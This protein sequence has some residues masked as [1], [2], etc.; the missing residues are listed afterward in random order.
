MRALHLFP[1][2]LGFLVLVLL[3]V[4]DSAGTAPALGVISEELDTP[5]YD[6]L[7]TLQPT[8]DADT[9]QVW[10]E[11]DGQGQGLRLRLT[12]QALVVDSISGTQETRIAKL[13]IAC[14]PDHP[15]RCFVLR[16]GG[17]LALALAPGEA[18]VWRGEVARGVGAR[19]VIIPGAGWRVDEARIQPLEPVVFADNFMRTKDES[20]G[21]RVQSGQWGLQSAWDADPRGGSDRFRN[22]SYAQNPFAWSGRGSTTPAWCLT[23]HPFWEDY[24]VTTAVNPPADGAVGVGVNLAA[25]GSGLLVRWTP[26]DDHRPGGDRLC[27]LRLV[28]GSPTELA[29]DRGGYLP[30]Q[31]Y[32]LQV[33]SSLTWA[34][35]LV[36]G[37]ERLA[38]E[39][40]TPWRGGVGLY[41]EGSRP[42]IFDDVTVYGR[43]LRTE[44]IAERRQARFNERFQ[45]DEAQM[46]EWAAAAREWQPFP[47]RPGDYRLHRWL[48]HGDAWLTLTVQPS[49]GPAGSCSLLLNG[50]G[51]ATSRGYR[52]LIERSGVGQPTYTLY[53]DTERLATATGARWRTGDEYLLRFQRSGHQVQLLVDGDV[54]VEAA[55]PQPLAGN[56]VAYGAAGC[57]AN[58][59]DA[60]AL[61]RN[62][63]D[64][65][66]DDAPVDWLAEGAWMPTTRWSCTPHWSYLGGWS[67]GEAV[68][69]HKQR[70]TGDQSL[71]AYVAPKMEYPRER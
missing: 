10:L 69:W 14:V 15:F 39:N 18:P 12:R 20:G 60:L 41:V 23:G 43:T 29:S 61:G 13:A 63:L 17:W 68:L 37:R 21:W 9:L 25:P 38:V 7:F 57:L 40:P 53:R 5:S 46:A 3:G 52:A 1:F 50:D 66:F 36:D 42:A 4:G 33:V 48:F 64:Y 24:T 28:G 49:A 65:S 6:C 22:A 58:V 35:V 55:D 31:W 16:R 26:A 45:R 51:V 2:L 8:A 67:R 71:Q 27:L 54:V 11:E 62:V 34:R 30:G 70:F 44:L 59:K 56:R 19:A 32:R 47:T